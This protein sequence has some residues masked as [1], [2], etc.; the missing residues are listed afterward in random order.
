MVSGLLHQCSFS[1]TNNSVWGRELEN[2][3][4]PSYCNS[5]TCKRAWLYL[6]RARSHNLVENFFSFRVTSD[7]TLACRPAEAINGWDPWWV[8]TDMELSFSLVWIKPSFFAFVPPSM[9]W[10]FRS[11]AASVQPS[12]IGQFFPCSFDRRRVCCMEWAVM[13]VKTLMNCQLAVAY[14]CWECLC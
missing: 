12:V 7:V 11:T 6:S 10:P 8:P 9:I 3:L 13:C 2:L 14:A 5:T 1:Y 4:L